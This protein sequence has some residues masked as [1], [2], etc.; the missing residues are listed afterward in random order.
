MPRKKR[1]LGDQDMCPSCYAPT[2][3]MEAGEFHWERI[4]MCDRCGKLFYSNG[5][6]LTEDELKELR[7]LRA[8]EN[9]AYEEKHGKV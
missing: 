4:V 2:G 8:K 3:L 5:R 1:G 6:Q 9:K 7:E